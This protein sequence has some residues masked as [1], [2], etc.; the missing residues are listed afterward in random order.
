[1]VIPAAQT[2]AHGMP[3]ARRTPRKPHIYVTA[4]TTAAAR[5]IARGAGVEVTF[6]HPG[7][8]G[9]EWCVFYKQS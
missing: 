8:A 2:H 3:W 4:L 7:R 1:M 5:E 6:V 9:G